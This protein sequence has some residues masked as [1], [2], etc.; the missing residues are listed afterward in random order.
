MRLRKLGL[1]LIFSLIVAIQ[2][3]S[4]G[5]A[6]AENDVKSL[7]IHTLHVVFAFYLLAL[8]ASVVNKDYSPHSH[9]IIHLS[10]LTFFA[11]G[12]LGVIGLVPSSQG[13]VAKITSLSSSLSEVLWYLVL[14]LYFVSFV[15]VVTT[16]SGPALHYPSER[17]YSDKTMMALSSNYLDNVCGITGVWS[18]EYSSFVTQHFPWL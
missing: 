6:I 1:A 18:L 8:T 12:L 3:A 10:A 16:P 17:I 13:P 9:A 2:A 14:A 4:L 7:P 15:V 11:S 5:W